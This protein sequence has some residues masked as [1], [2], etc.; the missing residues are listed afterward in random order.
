MEL[1]IQ[2]DIFLSLREIKKLEAASKI[3]NRTLTHLVQQYP[4]KIYPGFSTER[5]YSLGEITDLEAAAK[6][7]DQSVVD[8]IL[9]R[10]NV[11]SATSTVPRRMEG[12]SD[13]RYQPI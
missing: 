7:L 6:I 4:H 8:L 12:N 5:L 10:Q 13:S 3:L 1:T 11:P 9:Q 2:S